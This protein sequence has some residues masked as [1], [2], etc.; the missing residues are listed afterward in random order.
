MN[1]IVT[2][3]ISYINTVAIA[4]CAGIFRLSVSIGNQFS[5]DYLATAGAI[6]MIPIADPHEILNPIQW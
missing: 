5:T 1:K 2:L 6:L 4:V 3:T